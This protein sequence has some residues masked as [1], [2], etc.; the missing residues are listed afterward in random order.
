VPPQHPGE[1]GSGDGEESLDGDGE[2]DDLGFRPPLPP[3]DRLWRHPSEVAGGRAVV[4]AAAPTTGGAR[5]TA[6]LVLVS[7]VIGAGV[8]IASV[9][10]LGG[11]DERVVE[12]QV[13]VQPATVL[14]SDDG[15]VQALV[16][17]A[18]PSVAGL[19]VW[20]DGIVSS[21]SAV[22]LRPD[23]YLVTDSDA[24]RDA[25]AIDVVLHDGV[26]A[27]GRLVG[28]D[29]VT[30]ISV[31]HIDA[32]RLQPAEL[33]D[34]RALA[35]GARTVLV[36]A[37]V[38]GGW[39]AAVSTGVVAAMARRVEQDGGPARYGMIAVDKA[40]VPGVAGAA[41]VDT[42][43]TVVGIAGSRVDGVPHGIATPIEL[44]RHVAEQLIEHG[45]VHH[46]WLGL[47]GSDL[48][49]ADAAAMGSHGGALVEDVVADGPAARAGIEPGDVVVSVDGAPTSTMSALISAL[50]LHL[51][52]D[53]VVLELQRNGVRW[54]VRVDLAAKSG[55]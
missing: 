55:T 42:T 36:G 21:G 6:A 44:V 45:R 38:D 37:V 35:A 34:S 13:A 11:F 14:D 2:H 8:A 17:R 30:G 51:P 22:V 19:A 31:L 53:V 49:V 54:T 18:S 48:D 28:T 32:S 4:P 52:G 12:R 39:H 3:E 7:G 20:R 26:V 50:R 1:P 23:G 5:R 47:H 25:D 9:S 10:A 29:D 16:E 33:G 24:V 27:E 43:G 46:V 41:L 15:S 40:F